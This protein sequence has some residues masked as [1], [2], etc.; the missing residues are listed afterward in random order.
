MLVWG[1]SLAGASTTQ[2]AN[3]NMLT[4]IDATAGGAFATQHHDFTYYSFESKDVVDLVMKTPG[5]I[6]YSGLAYATDEVKM[7][8]VQKSKDQPAVMPTV[9]TAINGSYP[10]ARPLLMYTR[11]APQGMVK[12]YLDWILS[13]EGQTIIFNK[14]YAPVRTIQN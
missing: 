8:P 14:G 1:V 2:L 4:E 12:E 6:G 10:I 9:I 11:G 5:A 13:N 7:I 3:G